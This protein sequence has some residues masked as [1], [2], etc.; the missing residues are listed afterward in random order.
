MKTTI[1]ILLLFVASP[2]VGQVRVWTNAD[3]GKPLTHPHTTTPEEWRSIVAHQFVY[4]PTADPEPADGP[5]VSVIRYIP[6]TAYALRPTY[7][8]DPSWYNPNPYAPWSYL[9]YAYGRLGPGGLFHGDVRRRR[10]SGP[11]PPAA[12]P[13]PASR[14]PETAPVTTR[15]VGAGVERRR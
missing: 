11:R 9:G 10:E 12:S 3:L 15:G 6:P 7:P 5:H 13:P 4:V 14:P 2:A 8:L 1:L